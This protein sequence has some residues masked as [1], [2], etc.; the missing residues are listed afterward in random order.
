MLTH[1]RQELHSMGILYDDE[2][3]A[4]TSVN[5]MQTTP[6]F[7]IR[8]GKPRHTRHSAW[9]KLSLDISFYNLRDHAATAPTTPPSFSCQSLIQHRPIPNSNSNSINDNTPTIPQ[10]LPPSSPSALESIPE[11]R[12]SF[13]TP[14]RSPSIGDWTF[15]HTT[16]YTPVASAP[17]S[18]P[19]TWILL[20][21]D[22]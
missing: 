8:P 11:S 18:E 7:V 22:L 10:S 2:D 15:V 16:P 3:V 14:L 6:A 5:E 13:D 12:E 17:P 19:E 4:G 1:T 9:E 20:G 21:D